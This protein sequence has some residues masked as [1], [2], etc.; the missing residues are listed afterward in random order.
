MDKAKRE[1]SVYEAMRARHFIQKL[2]V[3]IDNARAKEHETK[4]AID[5][6]ESFVDRILKEFKKR[7][8]K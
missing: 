8:R 6:L 1:N 4:E 5:E 2:K 3:L 7:N